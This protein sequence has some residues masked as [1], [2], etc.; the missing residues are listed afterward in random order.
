[1][2]TAAGAAPAA[3]STPSAAKA[4]TPAAVPAKPA[5]AGVAAPNGKAAPVPDR[6]APNAPADGKAEAKPETPPEPP[7]PPSKRVREF[8]YGD[9]VEKLEFA[10]EAHEQREMQRL[11]AEAKRARETQAE[12]QA[13]RK[14]VEQAR[15][16]D[17]AELVK[18][19]K[20]GF[21]PD[22]WALERA[23]AMIA[24]SDARKADPKAYELSQ[25]EKAIADREAAFKAQEEAARTQ[26]EQ[27]EAQQWAQ[28]Q[29]TDLA[30][31]ARKT[32]GD[33]YPQEFVEGPLLSRMIDIYEASREA[34]WSMQDIAAQA[35]YE[36]QTAA[37]Q[38]IKGMSDDALMELL[39][40]RFESL[41]QKHLAKVTA[42]PPAPAIE[43][44]KD[45][46][47]PDMARPPTR[48]E[49]MEGFSQFGQTWRGRG[50]GW[51][52]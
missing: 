21:D 46:S 45:T 39:G 10:D 18:Q 47:D 38:H 33:A 8:R 26:R 7:K 11:W 30:Q 29:A 48:R 28:K 49:A 41:R 43:P 31:A 42:P 52:R 17:W 23:E 15:T 5:P 9:K 44:K 19:L 2:T 40:D 24:D 22:A 13:F 36:M 34:N 14:A 20:P 6:G 50:P 27:A 4:A 37:T 1:M 51:G 16:G 12:Q 32:F 3:P 25:R 35:Q